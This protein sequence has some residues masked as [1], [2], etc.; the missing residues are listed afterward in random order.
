MLRRT[1]QTATLTDADVAYIAANYVALPDLCRGR[2]TTSA[3][4]E[5]L[6]EAGLLPKA[7]YALR[8]G[9]GM[10]PADYFA[11]VDEAGGPDRLR[12]HF[13]DRFLAAGGK[14]T[15]LGDFWSAY[16]EGIWGVCLRTVS[17]ETMVRK[18]NLVDSIDALLEEPHPEDAGWRERLRH[19]V[20]ELDEIEREFAPDYDRN[21][22]FGRPPTRDL[23]IKVARER[24]PDIFA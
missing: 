10:F 17:P 13:E 16:L 15:E 18:S 19:G 5:E 24:F 20:D 6:I 2:T 21:G 9:T 4:V 3:G 14:P 8:D 11:L 23:L 7:S 22:R 1:M 12:D